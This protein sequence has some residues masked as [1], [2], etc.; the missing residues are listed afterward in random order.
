MS[1]ALGSNSGITYEI[2]DNLR[3]RLYT[4]VRGK[5]VT[6]YVSEV[7]DEMEERCGIMVKSYLQPLEYFPHLQH[8]GHLGV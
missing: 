3:Q 1:F 5:N 8:L 7:T 6:G 4:I 2:I